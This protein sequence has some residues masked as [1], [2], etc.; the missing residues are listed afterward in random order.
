[1]EPLMRRLIAFR[2][3][4]ETLAGSL[5]PYEGGKT[6]LLLVIGGSQTRI[7]SH[8]M[9]E[10]LANALVEKGYSCFRY[11]RRGVGDSSGEDPGFKGS[12]PDLKAAADALR[13]ELPA[14]TR[15][16]GFGLCDGA[17]ALVLFGDAAGL[18]GL[19]LVNP[20]LVE[21][22]AGE[23][24]P[25]AVRQH[26]RKQLLSWAGWKKLLTG[27][28]NYKKL[29]RGIRSIFSRRKDK[30]LSHDV[31]QALLRHR[32]PAEATLCVG[33]ATA[34]AA[35]AEIRGWPYEGL[36]RATQTIDT[37]SH[38]FARPGDE[39]MLLTAVLSALAELSEE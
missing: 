10:R 8:R 30:S 13:G 27:A 7:G 9:Y 17:T 25:A 24:P 1:M 33:D 2:C 26:Y 36:I 34:I 22:E 29:W 18:D 38:T 14:L 31:L 5:D 20:W 37:D 39:A 12:A 4:D 15:M 11:D 19:I 3:G 16:I 35:E 6:G 21:A 32:L 28:V 23:P